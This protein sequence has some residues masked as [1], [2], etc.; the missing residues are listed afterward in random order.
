MVGCEGSEAIVDGG[1]VKPAS[2]LCIGTERVDILVGCVNG[3]LECGKCKHCE[4]MK[5]PL[6]F[7]ESTKLHSYD[8]SGNNH[9]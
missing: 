7:V 6:A 3:V 8:S 5:V 1:H 4:D 2:C 9:L